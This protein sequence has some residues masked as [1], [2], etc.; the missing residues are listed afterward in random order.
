MLPDLWFKLQVHTTVYV[1]NY[2]RLS[3]QQNKWNK[4]M[5][6]NKSLKSMRGIK[7]SIKEQH[8]FS[9]ILNKQ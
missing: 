2:M 4:A 3:V 5:E 1:V 9:L 7:N 8:T 6:I